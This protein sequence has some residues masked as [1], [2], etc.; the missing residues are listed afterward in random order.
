MDRPPTPRW[1]LPR[2]AAG[3]RSSA[4]SP[5][6][7][8]AR[9]SRTTSAPRGAVRRFTRDRRRAHRPVPRDRQRRRGAHDVH[10]SR[11]RGRDRSESTSTPNASRAR[12]SPTSRATSGTARRPRT[13]SAAPC[14][15]AHDAGRK[16][17]LT[18]SDPFCV[19]RHRAEFRRADR[20]RTS[21][22]C[23]RT[24]T[25]S[26]CCTRS[27]RST[28]PPAA[29]RRALRDRR[30]HPRPARLGRRGRRRQH[31]IDG[32]ARRPRGR[33][34]RRRRPVRGRCPVRPHARSRPRNV[35]APRLPRRGRGDLAPRRAA[36]GVARRAGRRGPFELMARLPRYRT[37]D[38]ELDQHI[39]H[40]IATLGDVHD[41][42]P[43]VRADR[44][45]GAAR[46]R[47]RVARRHEDRERRAQ[48]DAVRVLGVRAVP[49][50]AEGRDLR[51]GAHD[52]A[53]IRCTSRRSRS[54]GSWP[55]S[56][57]W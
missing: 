6:T 14:S 9:C 2:S 42:R 29:I 7:R 23:S 33:H 20:G 38:A 1:V 17:A 40:L 25:R 4:G 52:A 30:A 35:R 57:G 49:L 16:V 55:R 8:S 3:R 12:R 24:R 21:T 47:P 48:G 11:R 50:G 43:R 27:T 56:T 15:L 45:G 19:D 28:R 53:T 31:V 10:V 5:T 13:R 39:D 54:R 41:S 34:H 44:V 32:R 37:G 36:R 46:A 26:R 22:S 51:L 18:L